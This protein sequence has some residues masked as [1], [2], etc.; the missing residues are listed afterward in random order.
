MMESLVAGWPVVY[1]SLSP[2]DP[3]SL[4]LIGTYVM[5]GS[6]PGPI[7]PCS[8]LVWFFGN[9]LSLP[10]LPLLP[11]ILPP[12]LCFL[13]PPSDLS[14]PPYPSISTDAL[15]ISDLPPSLQSLPPSDQSLRSLPPIPLSLQ[16]L[17]P[18]ESLPLDKF[19]R[20]MH[21]LLNVIH[22]QKP[23]H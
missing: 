19:R 4:P 8:V 9:R 17:P 10:S 5:Y 18:S 7:P 21:V 15:G 14:L 3:P 13:I 12:S 22:I 11:P 2:S 16:S 23:F 6:L 20:Y 1:Q